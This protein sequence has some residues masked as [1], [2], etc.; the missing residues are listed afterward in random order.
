M[1]WGTSFPALV[2]SMCSQMNHPRWDRK[3]H[4][5]YPST[6]LRTR[7]RRMVPCSPDWKFSQLKVA[8]QAWHFE[9]RC[10]VPPLPKGTS[11]VS[12]AAGGAHTLFLSSGNLVL[13]TDTWESWDAVSVSQTTTI[14]FHFDPFCAHALFKSSSGCCAMMAYLCSSVTIGSGLTML[15]LLILITWSS[16]TVLVKTSQAFFVS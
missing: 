3:T 16:S 11:Y 14:L 13:T 10:D 8:L 6:H 2:A 7:V 5:L 4:R 1:M 15:F 12:V 9:A